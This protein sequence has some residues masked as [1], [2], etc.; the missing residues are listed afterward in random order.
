MLIICLLIPLLVKIDATISEV[1]MTNDSHRIS[2]E[3]SFDAIILWKKK[4]WYILLGGI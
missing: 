4:N 2:Q 3:R 1:N